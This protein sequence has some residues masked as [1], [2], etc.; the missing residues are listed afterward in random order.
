MIR[1]T[2]IASLLVVLAL[3]AGCA[4][5]PT[6]TTA[7][8]PS[9]AAHYNTQLGYGYMSQG[10][11][12]LALQKFKRALRQ[13]DELSEAHEGIAVLY[14]RMGEAELAEEHYREALDITPDRPRL[15]DNYGVFICDQGRYEE[16][17]EHF[18]RA[19]DDPAYDDPVSAYVNAGV[20]ARRAGNLVEAQ[21]FFRQAL[22][23]NPRHGG[24]LLRLA[25]LDHERGETPQARALLDRF[26][27]VANATPASLFLG[28]QIESELGN[29]S[30]ARRYRERVLTEFP[31]SPE[32][33]RLRE[34]HG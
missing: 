13:D 31:D 34:T 8:N 3:A 30:E 11:R 25:R 26:H 16:A 15:H 1:P 17:I 12:Q 23:L 5:Q 19:A 18:R 28:F 7:G 33:R 10:K 6:E 21:G 32:A 29:T 22:Q 20:C 27:D 24:A 4:S 14:T 2:R 9:E